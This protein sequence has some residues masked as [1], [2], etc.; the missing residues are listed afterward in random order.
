MVTRSDFVRKMLWTVC[1]H[2]KSGR[3]KPFREI[4]M[5]AIA[6]EESPRAL[7]EF[8]RGDCQKA[9]CPYLDRDDVP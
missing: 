8:G 3:K 1:R 4:G 6:R 9:Q 2:R 5:C 7:L